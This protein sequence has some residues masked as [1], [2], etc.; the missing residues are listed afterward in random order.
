MIAAST[1]SL[2][3]P[4]WAARICLTS[5]SRARAQSQRRCGPI[6]PLSELAGLGLRSDRR[7]T[8]PRVASTAFRAT[9]RGPRAADST[10][11]TASYGLAARRASE[12]VTSSA[13]FGSGVGL[14]GP[15]AP[16]AAGSRSLLMITL[17]RSV[18]ETPSTM[19]WCVFEISAQRPSSRPSTTHISH[20]G[21]ARSSCWDITRPTRL[22]SSSSPPG[23]GRAVRRTW[24]SRLK[25]GSSTHV[26][27]PSASGT[28]RTFCRYRGT[29]GSRAAIADRTSPAPGTGPSKSPTEPMCMCVTASSMCRNDASSGLIVC[30]GNPPPVDTVSGPCRR[31]EPP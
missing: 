19:Q 31:R 6:G 25:C 24:Y 28:N 13:A 22:R 29:S 9:R 15:R 14:P 12:C 23:A 27:R 21:F 30:T 17:I 20:S 5:D 10:V 16:P 2:I 7:F 3:V 4:P 26:G 11:R 1:T 18:A 8:A